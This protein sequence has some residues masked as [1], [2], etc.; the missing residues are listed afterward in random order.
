MSKKRKILIGAIAL[1]ALG[2]L[3]LSLNSSVAEEDVTTKSETNFNPVMSSPNLLKPPPMFT[4][5]K[6]VRIYVKY[7]DPRTENEQK[8][9]SIPKV[10]KKENIEKILLGAYNLRFS[11]ETCGWPKGFSAETVL[12][13]RSLRECDDQPVR[14]MTEDEYTDY[15]KY[16]DYKKDSNKVPSGVLN[17]LFNIIISG[18]HENHHSPAF[19]DAIAT[20]NIVHAR[21]EDKLFSSALPHAF[22]I[23]QEDKVI[24][25]K[26]KGYVNGQIR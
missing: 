17:V 25:K 15:L 14:L 7:V 2:G 13:Y 22:P 4:D 11:S 1:L 16:T 20:Y 18:Y 6:E 19:E 21:P 3:F 8:T 23:T 12:E 5:V 9:Q 24:E 10:L 26:I